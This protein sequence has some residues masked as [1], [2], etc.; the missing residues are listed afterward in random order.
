MEEIG[1]NEIA[2]KMT[3]EEFL[4]YIKYEELCPS[5]FGRKDLDM[6]AFGA[7]DNKVCK[8]CITRMIENIKFKGED[9]M[10][11]NQEL[12]N[13]FLNGKIAV[14]CQTGDEIYSFLDYCNNQNLKWYNGNTA[15]EAL[16]YDHKSLTCYKFDT[17]GLQY[18][19]T[20]YYKNK[21]IKIIT[22][23]QLITSTENKKI[24]LYYGDEIL[25]MIRKGEI[26]RGQKFNIYYNGKKIIGQIFKWNGIELYNKPDG[27]NLN[28]K[29]Q[30]IVNNQLQFQ[31]IE[32]EYMT[33]D[34]AR[35]LGKPR[36][37]IYG[38]D[39]LNSKFAIEQF[40]NEIDKKVWEVE[41]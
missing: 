12:W 9:D 22:Y 21:N 25:T 23:Q 15:K 4:S 13:E 17:N 1:I 10:A 37:K 6:C 32:K 31:I 24:K 40:I 38:Y 28:L 8:N 41:D 30:D 16:C 34:E 33:F 3:R 35:K 19:N 20:Y 14:N 29:I 2:K 26:K 11:I 7:V 27:D 18:S 36:H 39:Y 5:A